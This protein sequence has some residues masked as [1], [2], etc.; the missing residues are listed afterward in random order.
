MLLRSLSEVACTTPDSKQVPIRCLLLCAIEAV[1][2]DLLDSVKKQSGC[3]DP[4]A[5]L[6]DSAIRLHLN[7]SA[8]IA[9]VGQ[10]ASQVPH[11]RHASAS[12][13]YL[14]SPSE[15]A[16]AGHSLAHVPQATHSSEITYAMIVIPPYI[17]R[18]RSRWKSFIHCNTKRRIRQV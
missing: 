2:W 16:S 18:I 13:T 14:P 12:I 4:T 3:I 7:Y 8:E 15:I 5:F 6:T 11:S 17:L 9:P 1:G 10:A